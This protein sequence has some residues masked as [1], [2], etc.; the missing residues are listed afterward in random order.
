MATRD[1]RPQDRGAD[2]PR[3]TQ[4]ENPQRSP[5]VWIAPTITPGQYCGAAEPLTRICATENQLKKISSEFDQRNMN[6]PKGTLFTAH[7]CANIF[8]SD[9]TSDVQFVSQNVQNNNAANR[10]HQGVT[11]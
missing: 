10:L 6:S 5:P 9:P 11:R 2:H 8:R 1:E 7:G 3:P 4:N